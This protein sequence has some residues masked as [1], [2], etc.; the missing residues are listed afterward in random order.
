[1]YIYSFALSLKLFFYV[2][3]AFIFC[4]SELNINNN[5]KCFSYVFDVFKLINSTQKK[6]ERW[7]TFFMSITFLN[8]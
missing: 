4:S 6:L 3:I 7:S 1:M 2:P 5:K 8:L